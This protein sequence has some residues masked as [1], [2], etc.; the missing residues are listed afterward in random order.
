MTRDGRLGRPGRPARCRRS[1]VAFLTED[2]F[3]SLSLGVI[4][5]GG[6]GAAFLAASAAFVVD[7]VLSVGDLAGHQAQARRGARGLVYSETPKEDRVGPARGDL[8]VVPAHAAARRRLARHGHHPQHRSSEE[9]S[10]RMAPATRRRRPGAFDIRNIIGA[11]LGDLRR[12]PHADGHLRRHRSP[13]RPAA[14]TPTSW[15]G[16][17]LLV[18]GLRL[19]RLGRLRPVK[20]PEHV[21]PVLDDP[22]RPAPRRR[23]RGPRTDVPWRPRARHRVAPWVRSTTVGRPP[24]LPGGAGG[25]RAV[26]RPGARARDFRPRRRDEAARRPA[27]RRWATSC[28]APDLLAR[29]RHGRLPGADHDRAAQG[30]GPGLRRPRGGARARCSPTPR[31]SGRSG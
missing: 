3:G 14:S 8:P 10:M 23:S 15:A 26:A 9:L 17:V 21:E 6:Q 18:M 13:T 4:P 5:L 27:R 24:G 16:L 29:G 2:A 25:R 1:L 22:T 31:A 30:Q 28:V 12:D 20:V 11:L 7:I 19:P